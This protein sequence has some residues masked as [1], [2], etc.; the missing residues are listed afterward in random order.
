MAKW[1]CERLVK[2][3]PRQYDAVSGRQSFNKRNDASL[4]ED[5]SVMYRGKAELLK[6]NNEES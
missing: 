3:T 4:L 6:Q 1:A 5:R 2:N